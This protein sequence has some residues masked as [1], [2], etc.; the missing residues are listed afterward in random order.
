VEHEPLL[1]TTVAGKYRV[2]ALVARGGMAMVLAATH[3]PRGERVAIKVVN[4]AASHATRERFLHEARAAAR[5]RNPHVARFLEV[6]TLPDGTPFLVME[7]LDGIDLGV[8]LDQTYEGVGVDVAVDYVLQACEALAEAHAAGIVHRD[9]K[10]ANLFLARRSDDSIVLKV[11]DFGISY[12]LA[13][14]DHRVTTADAVLGTPAY[15]A[16]EQMRSA[17]LAD[18][19]SD[20]WSLGAVLYELIESQLPFDAETYPE[21]CM[22]IAV[23]PPWPMEVAVPPGLARAIAKCLE[24]DPRARFQ[25]VADLARAIVPYAR[26]VQQGWLRV[27]RIERMVQSN[28]QAAILVAPPGEDRAL[29]VIRTVRAR[30]PTPRQRRTEP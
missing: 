25:T 6:G 3:V 24:K 29:D 13:G 17:R 15:M 2:D 30:V 28:P 20:I 14:T 27:V 5:L 11:L 21:L 1:H 4:A 9:I 8:V 10:P 26:D 16:P 19:R 18:A 12:A 7:L 22:T 23:D